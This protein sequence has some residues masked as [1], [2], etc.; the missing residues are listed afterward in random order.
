MQALQG[1]LAHLEHNDQASE[2]SVESM[3][4][5]KLRECYEVQFSGM[6]TFGEKMSIM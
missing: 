6:K 2:A 1:E 3:K 4:R 5:Q